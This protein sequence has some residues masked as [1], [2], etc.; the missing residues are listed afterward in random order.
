[1]SQAVQ[2]VGALVILAAFAAAQA[3]RLDVR[4]RTYLV[5]NVVGAGALALDAWRERQWGFLLLEGVWALVAAFGLV[6]EVRG[7]GRVQPGQ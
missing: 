2:V 4:S 1:M 3:R 7:A 5:L 6:R